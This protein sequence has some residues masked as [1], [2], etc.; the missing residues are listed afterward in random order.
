LELDGRG[1]G[2]TLFLHLGQVQKLVESVLKRAVRALWQVKRVVLSAYVENEVIA[3]LQ[4]KEL[5]LL[6]VSGK[7]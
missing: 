4:A 5:L 7:S 2:S 6:R 3:G 1:E